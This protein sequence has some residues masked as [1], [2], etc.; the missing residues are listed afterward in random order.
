M[1]GMFGLA[2][3]GGRI[4]TVARDATASVQREAILDVACTTGWLDPQEEEKNLKWVREFYRDLFAETG[5]VPV[6][7]AQYDGTFINH[8][9]NDLADSAWN[10]SGV[11][12]SKLYYNENYPR[13]QQIKARWDPLN[14]F[15]HALSIEGED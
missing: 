11:A 15:H 3:Y 7:N 5:G 9:D 14:I 12:W 1:G 13:L 10:T 2:T 6:P 8:P 4:N